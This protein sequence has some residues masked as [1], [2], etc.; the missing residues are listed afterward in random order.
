METSDIRAE[1]GQA[2]FEPGY[3]QVGFQ[4]ACGASSRK[5]LC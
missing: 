3:A 4:P 2:A 5:W 1:V